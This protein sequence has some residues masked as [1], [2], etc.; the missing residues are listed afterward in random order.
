MSGRITSSVTPSVANC[1][2]LYCHGNKAFSIIC[3][4]PLANVPNFSA[5]AAMAF[6][7]SI[8]NLS[9]IPST[10]NSHWYCFSIECFGSDIIF[11]NSSC[12]SSFN[13]PMVLNL[14]INSGINPNLVKSL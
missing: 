1:L 11:T 9:S 4:N 7:A 10:L 14:P 6:F 13:T 8:G 5:L 2:A 3:L 12:V